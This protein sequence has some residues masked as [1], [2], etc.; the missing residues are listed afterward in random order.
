M[1]SAMS[2]DLLTVKDGPVGP[3]PPPVCSHPR[4]L[5]R[6]TEMSSRHADR[7]ACQYSPHG[8]RRGPFPVSVGLRGWFHS[9]AYELIP[10]QRAARMDLL[11]Y[12]AQ[13]Q[14]GSPRHVTSDTAAAPACEPSSATN[15][16]WASASATPAR[17]Y[18]FRHL[19]CWK[20]PCS[21]T[22]RPA[23][24]H[25]PHGASIIF[26]SARQP[27][28]QRPPRRADRQLM[29]MTHPAFVV[30]DP[31]AADTGWPPGHRHQ[32]PSP[33]RAADASLFIH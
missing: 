15:H 13:R 12:R 17:G 6:R 29:S 14:T 2:S 1:N 31:G 27:G 30:D 20:A 5:G 10:L 23:W 11:G 4:A 19:G 9:P 28:P 3:V 32:G 25:R 8:H 16:A 7:D 26:N 21:T 18:G 33:H 24:M 22:T